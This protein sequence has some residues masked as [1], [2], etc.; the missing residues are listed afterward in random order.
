MTAVLNLLLSATL[1]PLGEGFPAVS[2]KADCNTDAGVDRFSLALTVDINE[3]SVTLKNQ[4]Q[5]HI[6][7]TAS[8]HQ[9]GQ[10]GNALTN[11]A[12]FLQDDVHPDRKPTA[13]L[14]CNTDKVL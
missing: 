3:L 5:P 1:S 6:P 10:R 7:A 8:H 12:K 9:I 13:F 11:R 4:H 14:L 2:G